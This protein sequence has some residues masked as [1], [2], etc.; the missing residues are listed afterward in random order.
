VGD[1]ERREVLLFSVARRTSYHCVH[2]L[3]SSRN[4]PSHRMRACEDLS[5]PLGLL[6]T[7]LC[8]TTI[9]DLVIDDLLIV[10][11]YFIMITLLSVKNVVPIA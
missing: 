8:S 5:E 10:T 11:L 3:I 7:I 9:S 4:V 6:Y 1:L 2:S